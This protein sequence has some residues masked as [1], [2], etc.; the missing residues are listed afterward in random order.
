MDAQRLA[1]A[2][3]AVRRRRGWSQSQLGKASG[4]SQPTISRLERGHVSTLSLAAIERVAG[5]LELRLDLRVRWRGGEL[6]RLLDRDH[7]ALGGSV[8][9]WLGAAGWDSRPE[10]SFAHYGERGVIDILAWHASTRSLLMIELKT[11]VIDMQDL[12]AGVDRKV[13]LAPHAAA[14]IGWRAQAVSGLVI[15]GDSRTNRRRAADH[16]ELLHAAF[17]MDGRTVRAWLR[18]PTGT[19]R[20][21]AFWPITHQWNGRQRRRS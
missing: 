15:I 19:M 17:P 16:R 2:C 12:I 13:R 6:D 18:H 7:A 14:P 5:A 11:A 1:G 10:V 21:L 9:R 3:R 20:G 8:L 4:V